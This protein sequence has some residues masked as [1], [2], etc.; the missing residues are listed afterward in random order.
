MEM[1]S[2]RCDRCCHVDAGVGGGG[3]FSGIVT[4]LV[5]CLVLTE[6]GLLM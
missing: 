2:P 1:G 6:V 3:I 4:V 5:M